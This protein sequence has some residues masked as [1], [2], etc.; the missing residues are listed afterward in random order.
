VSELCLGTMTFGGRGRWAAV[1]QLGQAE[2]DKLVGRALAAGINFLDTADVYGEGHSELITGQALKN[3]GVKR[4][5]VVIATKVYNPTGEGP[6]D[7]G[8]SRGHIMDAVKASLQRLQLDYIDLYQ[9]H[10][11]DP[12]TPVDEIMRALDDLTRQGLVRYFG[13][14]NWA[15]W[16]IMKAIGIS[17]RHGW[18]R[19]DTLQAY[20]ALNSRDVEREIVPLLEDQ[21]LG[22]LV[23][24]P[25]SGGLLSGKFHRE[26]PQPEGAR[27]AAFDFPPVDKERTWRIL[28]V[29][30]PFAAAHGVSPARVAIAWLLTRPAVTSVII[31]A[32]TE[33]QLDDNIGAAGLKLAPEEVA[34]LNEVSALPPEYPG[35]MIGF[36][37]SNRRVAAK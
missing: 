14:S 10:G 16:Q 3:L 4:T 9:I 12:V 21:K 17:A 32:K 15:A 36:L 22:L 27:R 19:P 18:S 31:G 30:R 5:D 25:L 34:R 33:E 7:R 24:S 6:N 28:E 26:G 8:A 37:G 13:V 23:W 11:T 35:W 20:Y 29:M 1:G 2:A